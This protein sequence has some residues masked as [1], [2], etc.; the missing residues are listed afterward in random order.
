MLNLVHHVRPAPAGVDFVQQCARRIV[1]PRR[2]R[3]LGLQIVAFQSCPALQGVMMPG[4]AGQV[5]ID[6]QVSVRRMSSP[7]RS[8]SLIRTAMASWNFSRKRTSSTQVSSGRPHMLT[9]YQGGRGNDPVVVLGK[10]RLA[11]AVNTGFLQATSRRMRRRASLQDVFTKA[12]GEGS[13]A[14][15]EGSGS[16]PA[17]TQQ[18][19]APGSPPPMMA[20]SDSD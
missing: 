8:W 7:A 14:P 20:R 11:V 6:V 3:L 19:F 15:F 13:K 16:P 1:Q 17:R 2:R 18:S 4:P 5:L 9:S 10:I 12:P